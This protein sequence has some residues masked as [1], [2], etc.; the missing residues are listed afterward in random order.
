[1]TTSPPAN[2]DNPPQGQGSSKHATYRALTELQA[3]QTRVSVLQEIATAITRR[4]SLDEI[5]QEV[6]Q[7]VKWLLDFDHC[8]IYLKQQTD[9]FQLMTL[10][11]PEPTPTDFKIGSDTNLI[12]QVI[13]TTQPQLVKNSA[14]S[15]NPSPYQAFIIVPLESE[16]EILGTL[17]FAGRHPYNFNDLRL[18]NLLSMQLAAAI[19]N[20]QHFEEINH[21]YVELEHTYANLR[22]VE[23]LRDDLTR[24]IVHD[25]RN[26]LNVISGSLEILEVV[27]NDADQ[28]AKRV[29]WVRNAQEA[30][31][32]M[33]TMIDDLLD[34]SRLDSQQLPLN[35]AP[36]D[37]TALLVDKVQLYQ[38]QAERDK[39][40]LTVQAAPQLPP[41]MADVAII[42]RVLDNLVGNAFKY[43]ANGSQIELKASVAASVIEVTVSDDGEGIPVEYHQRIFDKFI[44]VHND[45]DPSLRKGTGLGLAFCR[46][47]VEAHG[48]HIW[49]DSA[50][51]QGSA[52]TFTLPL[53][54]NL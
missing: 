22:Q 42:S 30:S 27:L 3:Y 16:D 49:V 23:E 36:V 11:G 26:P 13:Q 54:S 39:K 14:G 20:A 15:T 50:P 4:L 5:L 29:K 51:G 33:L 9:T 47:A 35:L 28:A 10:F 46:L 40:M 1:M 24:I 41:V 48:G 6:K 31:Q 7:R 8:S 34:V 44:Q 25:L 12:E 38:P 52:F 45:N 43:T 18:C 2:P 17:N 19:R 53:I 32:Q 37:I 21:L